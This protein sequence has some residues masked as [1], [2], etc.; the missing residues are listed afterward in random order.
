MDWLAPAGFTRFEIRHSD[1]A[2][3]QDRARP[4]R[5]R[6]LPRLPGRGARPGRPPP[7]LPVH[8]LHQLR[9]ALHASSRRCPTTGPT[10][11]CAAFALCPA[12]QAE[13]DD[14][15]DR[16]FHAQPNA[17]PVCGPQLAFVERMS[18]RK[19]SDTRAR[20]QRC[21]WLGDGC[22]TGR[23]QIRGDTALRAAE[24]ALR[25]GQIVAVKGLGGFHLMVDAGNADASAAT[26][27]AQA[28]AGQAACASWCATWRRRASLCDRAARRGQRC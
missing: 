7:S 27:R 18:G 21:T 23:L 6:H 24:D 4:A 12:C 19:A 14:P 26:A 20:K 17:C 8:Q 2:G 13:Y 5:H 10:P 15:L 1:D 11:P 16:R 9:P 22:T 3:P 25:A 28:A